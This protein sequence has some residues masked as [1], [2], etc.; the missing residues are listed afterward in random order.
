MVDVTNSRLHSDKLLACT[1]TYAG[2]ML[3]DINSAISIIHYYYDTSHD[4]SHD[5][6]R[7]EIYM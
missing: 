6:T 2:S 1:Q 7:M 4:T 5:T 3:H